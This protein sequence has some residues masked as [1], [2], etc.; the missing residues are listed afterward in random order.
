MTSDKR[1][2]AVVIALIASMTGG[3]LVLA[4]FEKLLYPLRPRYVAD[5]NLTALTPAEQAAVDVEV[6]CTAEADLPAAEDADDFRIYPNGQIAGEVR[7]QHVRLVVVSP[8]G[9]TLADDQKRALLGAL[10]A[11][12]GDRDG[13]VAPVRVVQAEGTAAPEELRRFLALKGIIRN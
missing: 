11:L 5:I 8:D 12:V 13:D 1:N 7:G 4:G 10:K 6:L 3:V 9:H 2:A